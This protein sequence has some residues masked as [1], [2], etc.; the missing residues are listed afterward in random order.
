M[1]EHKAISD[2]SLKFL[3]SLY[4]ARDKS[5]VGYKEWVK[6]VLTNLIL[7][8]EAVKPRHFS[9]NAEEMNNPL[10]IEEVCFNFIFELESSVERTDLSKLTIRDMRMQMQD[11]AV[12]RNKLAILFQALEMTFGGQLKG[13]QLANQMVLSMKVELNLQELMDTLLT[14]LKKEYHAF[15]GD[16]TQLVCGLD[17]KSYAWVLE[18][19]KFMCFRVLP[20]IMKE[21]GPQRCLKW[22]G[23]LTEGVTQVMT[24]Q[25]KNQHKACLQ[26][27]VELYEFAHELILIFGVQAKEAVQTLLFID[28]DHLNLVPMLIHAI[29]SIILLRDQTTIDLS[30]SGKVLLK[31]NSIKD[32]FIKVGKVVQSPSESTFS[33]QALTSCLNAEHLE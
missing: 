30:Q 33:L 2:L 5:K 28:I 9:D 19:T 32:Q 10:P 29:K 26:R 17:Q 20:R 25:S 7:Y 11:K 6:R 23:Q 18:E 27:T 1:E 15:Q 24:E 21:I 4:K 13:Q 22:Q 16:D 12:V 3:C 31:Q 14:I 8:L